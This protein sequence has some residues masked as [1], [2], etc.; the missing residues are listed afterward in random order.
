MAAA[1]IDA[2]LAELIALRLGGP[3][4]EVEAFLGADGDGRAPAGSFGARIQLALLLGIIEERDV[5]TL[6]VVKQVRNLFAH[7]TKV[8]FV[9]PSVVA[10]T[11]KLLEQTLERNEILAQAGLNTAFTSKLEKVRAMLPDTPEAGEGLLLATLTIYQAYF[12]RIHGRIRPLNKA[13]YA[14][15]KKSLK[16]T[17]ALYERQ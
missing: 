6:R 7:C 16:Y 9:T 15:S 14:P 5:A 4:G 8:T 12:H 1:V 11:K 13:L 17:R 10:Q 2:A 3:S